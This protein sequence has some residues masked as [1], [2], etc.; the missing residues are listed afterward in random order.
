MGTGIAHKKFYEANNSDD[1]VRLLKDENLYNSTLA[2]SVSGAD[3]HYKD[4]HT[5]QK[6]IADKFNRRLNVI[7]GKRML[8]GAA[9]V[10]G[11]AA[12][13][14]KGINKTKEKY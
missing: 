1:I 4:I 6:D 5:A 13:V 3:Q 10:A 7:H 11:G 14:Y 9:L 12:L 2:S 8:G